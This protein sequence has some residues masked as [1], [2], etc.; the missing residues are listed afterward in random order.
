M[1]IYWK[2]SVQE[3]KDFVLQNNIRMG[4]PSGMNGRLLKHDYLSVI[5][6]DLDSLPPKS[7]IPCEWLLVGSVKMCG[8]PSSLGVK[9]SLMHEGRIRDG[10]AISDSCRRCN[11]GTKSHLFTRCGGTR[12]NEHL[13]RVEERAR[14]NYTL[15]MKELDIHANKCL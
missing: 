12:M 3:L 15:V 8:R 7:I 4:E 13:K 9:F 11:R 2:K 1:A 14:G 10:K 5:K 6:N